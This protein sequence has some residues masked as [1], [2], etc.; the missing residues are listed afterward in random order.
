MSKRSFVDSGKPRYANYSLNEF[1]AN[2]MWFLDVAD[3]CDKLGIIRMLLANLNCNDYSPNPE[4][5]EKLGA[6]IDTIQTMME[7]DP[8]H[9]ENLTH[10]YI[11]FRFLGDTVTKQSD[12]TNIEIPP[13]KEDSI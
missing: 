5:K 6:M 9:K 10:T 11:K 12:I 4:T 8:T 2:F 7:E 3:A 1:V 13:K